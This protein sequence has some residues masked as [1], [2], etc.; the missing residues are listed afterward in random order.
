MSFKTKQ[1]WNIYMTRDICSECESID[2]M[3]NN[4]KHHNEQ[5][6]TEFIDLNPFKSI[7]THNY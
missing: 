6:S 5:K 4:E 7:F 3:I 1:K 2:F